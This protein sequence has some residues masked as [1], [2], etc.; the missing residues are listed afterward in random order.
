MLILYD[1]LYPEKDQLPV[2]DV[3][4]SSST[5]I[6]AVTCIWIHLVKKAQTEKELKKL[7]RPIPHALKGHL[8]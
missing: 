1:L 7:Q 4:K 5:H 2:P 3:S 8:E 6:M